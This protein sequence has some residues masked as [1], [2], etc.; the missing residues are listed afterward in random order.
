LW[1]KGRKQRKREGEELLVL[2]T[3]GGVIKNKSKPSG[4]NKNGMGARGKYWYQKGGKD[5]THREERETVFVLSWRIGWRA[6][7]G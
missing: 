7:C 4:T 2:A 6:N 3:R 5:R 1:I